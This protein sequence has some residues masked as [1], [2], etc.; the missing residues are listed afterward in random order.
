[1]G[2]AVDDVKRFAHSGWLRSPGWV[3]G[4]LEAGQSDSAILITA[5]K[6]SVGARRVVANCVGLAA[7][8]C[9]DPC[10]YLVGK[11]VC[12]AIASRQKDAFKAAQL[13]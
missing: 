4:C 10:G 8:G 13:I 11:I 6:C 12:F 2:M 1:M 3:S 9:P 7:Q 5:K